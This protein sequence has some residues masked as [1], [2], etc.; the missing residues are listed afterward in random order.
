MQAKAAVVLPSKSYAGPVLDLAL[1]AAV[2]PEERPGRQPCHATK[3]AATAAAARQALFV[4]A[5]AAAA[6]EIP[7][8]CIPKSCAWPVLDLAAACW[9]PSKAKFLEVSGKF[10][11][12]Q[13]KILAEGA[14]AALQR[15]EK[16]KTCPL[17]SPVIIF[18]KSSPVQNANEKT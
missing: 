1:A 5:A 14:L 9:P 8:Y 4:S 17:S 13:Y 3:G 7:K 11:E 10:D 2:Q 6:A 18:L 15:A 16:K 12:Q